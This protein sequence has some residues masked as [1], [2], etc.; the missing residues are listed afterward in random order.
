MGVNIETV[1]KQLQD[2]DCKTLLTHC[3]EPKSF[4]EIRSTKIKEGKLFKALKDL[5]MSEA[6]LFADGKYYTSPDVL[7]FLD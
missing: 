5:K 7:E 6:L 4:D 2:L 3:K 1:K